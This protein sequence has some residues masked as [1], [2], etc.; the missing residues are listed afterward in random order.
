MQFPPD[1]SGQE[2]EGLAKGAVQLLD[3]E[4]QSCDDI[5]W[6]TRKALTHLEGSLFQLLPFLS[7]LG[8]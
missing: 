8:T 6:L 5:Y 3:K 2:C 1:V 7:I 4:A